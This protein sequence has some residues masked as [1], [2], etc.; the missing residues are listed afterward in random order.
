M[1]RQT[2]TLVAAIVGLAVGLGTLAGVV[3]AL[4]SAAADDDGGAA[5]PETGFADTGATGALPPIETTPVEQTR[6][7]EVGGLPYAVAVGEGGV[8]VARDGRRLIRIDPAAGEVVARIGAGDELGSDRACGIAVGAGAVW[9]TTQSGDLARIN[10]RTNRLGA[11]V[12][13]D[14]AA[15]VAVGAGGV[16]VTEPDLDLV[17]RVDPQTNE[18]VAQI[19]V[20]GSPLGVDTGFGGVWVAAPDSSAVARIDRREDAVVETIEVAGLPEYVATGAGGVWVSADDG[21]IRRIDPR[22]GAL[23]DRPV[24]VADEGRTT[25]TV[26]AGSVWA[27][28]IG[29]LDAEASVLRI[30]P[31]TAEPAGEP[32]AGGPTPL[33]M[34][35]GAGSLWIT[36]LEAGTVTAYTPPTEA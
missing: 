33:G 9:V 6:T 28:G 16:W 13:L 10:P 2:K 14:G 4:R 29:T 8:W 22:S 12:D 17:T 7:I 11:V 35:Y 20:E 15:C 1:S 19:P 18:A 23:D 30:D 34:A 3:L 24:Q 25:L 5:L 26:G 36:N 32:I 31:A 21:A 27:A